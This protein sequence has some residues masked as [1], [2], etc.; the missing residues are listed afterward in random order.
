MS[1]KRPIRWR[2]LAA[3]LLVSLFVASAMAAIVYLFMNDAKTSVLERD[4]IQWIGQLLETQNALKSS[5]ADH[6][7][8]VYFGNIFCHLPDKEY[9]IWIQRYNQDKKY[10]ALGF[11]LILPNLDPATTDPSEAKRWGT[12]VG[13]GKELSILVEFGDNYIN[14]KKMIN[15]LFDRANSSMR[16][17]GQSNAGGGSVNQSNILDRNK[18]TTLRNGCKRYDGD[19]IAFDV[20]QI[21]HEDEGPVLISCK[22]GPEEK[23][24]KNPYCHAKINVTEGMRVSYSY[25]YAYFEESLELHDKLLTLL[26]SFCTPLRG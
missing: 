18:F 16:R 24:S 5:S 8:D 26:R 2:F 11:S 23:W 10:G 22:V 25:G 13:W 19:A 4:K 20:I 14:S 17:Q 7:T 12:G 21:C 3:P 9:R 6:Y 15:Y 1:I